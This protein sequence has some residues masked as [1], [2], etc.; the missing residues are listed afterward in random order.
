MTISAKLISIQTIGFSGENTHSSL[1][2]LW[3]I[4][5][6]AS[7][8]TP[9]RPHFKM[10]SN[11]FSY[12]CG[13]SPSDHFCHYDIIFNSAEILRRFHHL[14]KPHPLVAMVLTNQLVLAIFIEDYL[15]NIPVKFGKNWPCG[16]ELNC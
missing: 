1:C 16:I 12:F 15:G 9:R 13:K 3:Y 2:S 4:R 7:P 14:K 10:H 11:R 6:T 8:P 5:E